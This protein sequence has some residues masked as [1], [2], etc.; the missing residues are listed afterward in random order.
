MNRQHAQRLAERLRAGR[1]DLLV[2]LYRDGITDRTW[3]VRTYD[4]DTRRTDTFE[5]DAEVQGL[6]AGGH[7]A[8]QA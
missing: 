8:R 3:L 5:S 1:P 4:P 6:M 2:D 7:L